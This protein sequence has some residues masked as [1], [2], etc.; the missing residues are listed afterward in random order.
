MI[1]KIEGLQRNENLRLL[2]LARNEIELLE[3]IEHLVH[4]RALYL[5]KT[6]I[7]QPRTNWNSAALSISPNST[8]ANSKRWPSHVPPHL[9][10]Q[11]A[12]RLVL[13]GPSAPPA[14]SSQTSPDQYSLR[15]VD[16]GDSLAQRTKN[17]LKRRLKG[18]DI[19]YVHGW[20][21]FYVK[22]DESLRL[23]KELFCCQHL[24][25]CPLL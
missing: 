17:S 19:Q 15:H 16:D 3:N 1:K 25:R 4:L 11:G 20:S 23:I 7:M 24:E 13:R 9:F 2:S 18:V 10:S 22:K 6:S 14:S 8:S 12:G 5:S 21:F